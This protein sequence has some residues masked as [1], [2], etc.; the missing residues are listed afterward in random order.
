MII[1]TDDAILRLL[2]Y[3]VSGLNGDPFRLRNIHGDYA[4]ALFNVHSV[5]PHQQEAVEKTMNR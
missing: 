2:T 5:R 1:K 4:V 3:E